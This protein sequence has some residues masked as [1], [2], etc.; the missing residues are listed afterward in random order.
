MN[1]KKIRQRF[2]KTSKRW[3]DLDDFVQE[4]IM[5]MEMCTVPQEPES[6]PRKKSKKK[7]DYELML[8]FCVNCKT[9]GRLVNLPT[10]SRTNFHDADDSI[11]IE[12]GKEFSVYE[13]DSIAPSL[14]P[15]LF[16]DKEL[17]VPN[18]VRIKYPRK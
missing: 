3:E 17:E 9:R 6:P 7:K 11:S 18:C 15:G 1:Y 13:K 14:V 4:N 2:L 12:L 10:H 8:Y 5:T 16:R